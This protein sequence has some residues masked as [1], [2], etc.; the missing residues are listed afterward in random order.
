MMFRK[1]RGE[2]LPAA[3]ALQGLALSLFG[4]FLATAPTPRDR[5]SAGGGS[6]DSASQPIAHSLDVPTDLAPERIDL[7]DF[8]DAFEEP[9]VPDEPPQP[10]PGTP[11]DQPAS[12][13]LK[14]AG[15]HL[16]AVTLAN[17]I[18]MNIPQPSLG[19][20]S[21]LTPFPISVSGRPMTA[22]YR[23]G[24]RSDGGAGGRGPTPLGPGSDGIGGG[25]GGIGGGG[26]GCGAGPGS[27]G[28]PVGGRPVAGGSGSKGRPTGASGGGS[29]G[30]GRPTGTTGS[31]PSRGRPTGT[32]GGSGPSRTGGNKSGGTS[33]N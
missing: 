23:G 6:G 21:R 13:G 10:H 4:Y 18:A 17:P 20:P 33:K 8:P 32:V 29:Q 3:I 7:P 28:R 30:G 31:G 22:G 19:A 12:Q 26:R 9:E 2:T 1:L 24:R 25:V 16:D 27:V 11:P 14:L 15:L 5:P